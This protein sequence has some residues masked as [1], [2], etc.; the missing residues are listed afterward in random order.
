MAEA[1][2]VVASA[3]AV[4]QISKEVIIACKFYIE[5]LRSDAPT[6]LRTILI[7]VST[8]KPV[9]ENLEFISKCET[10][11]ATLQNRLAASDGPIEGCRAAMTA[12]VKLFP[13][14]SLQSRQKN[15]SK[16]QKLEAAFATLADQSP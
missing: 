8:L 7:E 14:R 12:L 11:T 13:K 2:G 10:F 5:A 6:S 9:L 15:T 4:I 1:L 3:I 16:R